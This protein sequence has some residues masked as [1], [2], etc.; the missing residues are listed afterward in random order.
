M[1]VGFIKYASSRLDGTWGRPWAGRWNI[2]PA[3]GGART[4]AGAVPGRKDVAHTGRDRAGRAN[5]ETVRAARR[6]TIEVTVQLCEPDGTG[7][8]QDRMNR[9]TALA[10]PSSSL[11]VVTRRAAAWT[12]WLA[13][14]MAILSPEWANM[15]TSLGWSPIVAICSGGSDRSGKDIWPRRPC[16]RWDW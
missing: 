9:S 1:A 13:L 16:W 3:R 4:G 8:T 7:E 6:L 15:S 10:K 11:D 5:S 2:E 12:S 14:P